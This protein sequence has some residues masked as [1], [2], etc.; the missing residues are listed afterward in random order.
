MVG[1]GAWAC[2]A[3]RMV[4]QNCAQADPAEEFADQVRMWVYEEDYE[5]GTSFVGSEVSG[6]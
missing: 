3:V 2:A 6:A 5:V 4:A 1:S